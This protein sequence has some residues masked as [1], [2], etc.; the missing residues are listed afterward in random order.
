MGSP[1]MVVEVLSPSNSE[2]EMTDR[3]MTCFEG[4]CLEFWMVDLEKRLIEIHRRDGSVRVYGPGEA[5]PFSLTNAAISFD[6][7]FPAQE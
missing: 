6:Q 3:R 4:G 7:I 1:E 2:A 5:M